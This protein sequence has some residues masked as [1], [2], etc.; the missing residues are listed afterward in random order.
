[1]HIIQKKTFKT[2]HKVIDKLDHLFT[3][4]LEV[5]GFI[6]VPTEVMNL[7]ELNQSR[8]KSNY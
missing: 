7:D 6:T 2:R 8:L 4:S 3:Y 1:M 5:S